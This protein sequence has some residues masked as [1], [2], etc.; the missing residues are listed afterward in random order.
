MVGTGQE[1]YH[2]YDKYHCS[3][4]HWA[5]EAA[6]LVLY[7]APQGLSNT[8]GMGALGTTDSC[9]LHSQTV[10]FPSGTD[11]ILHDPVSQHCSRPCQYQSC[12]EGNSPCS[13]DPKPERNKESLGYTLPCSATLLVPY[14]GRPCLAG[15]PPCRMAPRGLPVLRGV[16]LSPA[17]SLEQNGKG[18][19]RL[20]HAED[21]HCQARNPAAGVDPQSRG[22]DCHVWMPLQ[23]HLSGGPAGKCFLGQRHGRGQ[24]GQSV[25]LLI[26]LLNLPFLGAVWRIALFTMSSLCICVKTS[27]RRFH[28]TDV[29]CCCVC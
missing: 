28:E 16:I 11:L 6:L 3:A 22:A 25:F 21:A 20:G 4:A 29:H 18:S 7:L 10:F 19:S 23:L 9:Q 12:G 15:D 27:K 26:L 13:T 8:A 1:I 14:K 24:T 17:A 5:W 2:S